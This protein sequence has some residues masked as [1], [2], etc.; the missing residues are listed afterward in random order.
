MI[1]TVFVSHDPFSDDF[2]D[3][4][5]MIKPVESSIPDPLRQAISLNDKYDTYVETS[6][7][8]TI[9]KGESNFSPT[10]DLHIN[11][12]HI[13][14]YLTILALRTRCEITQYRLLFCGLQT[15]SRKLNSPLKFL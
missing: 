8:D 5:Q 10:Q 9:K 1:S 15:R 6:L 14:R 4:L 7:R 2:C 13:P 11:S 3:L 12:W